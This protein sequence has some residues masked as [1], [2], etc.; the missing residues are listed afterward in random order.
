[1][2]TPPPPPP[3]VRIGK[4]RYVDP[5]PAPPAHPPVQKPTT[6]KPVACGRGLLLQSIQSYDKEDL[7]RADRFLRV[8]SAKK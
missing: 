8:K 4:T 1:M 2:E 5:P 7:C 3:Q 6:P